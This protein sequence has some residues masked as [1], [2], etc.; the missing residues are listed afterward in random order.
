MLLV[1]ECGSGDDAFLVHLKDLWHKQWRV[2]INDES[3]IRTLYGELQKLEQATQSHRSQIQVSPF[4]Q[5]SIGIFILKFD[6]CELL[7]CFQ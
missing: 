4:L 7:C 6:D 3:R 1:A 5:C 2:D